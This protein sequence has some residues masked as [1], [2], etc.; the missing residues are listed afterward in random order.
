MSCLL[1]S[2]PGGG[3]GKT[4]WGLSL[5][6]TGCTLATADVVRGAVSHW[7]CADPNLAQTWKKDT[8]LPDEM[9]D[10]VG[11]SVDWVDDLNQR[12]LAVFVNAPHSRAQRLLVDQ[13]G[14][15]GLLTGP[16]ADGFELEDPH[17]LE[18]RVVGASS[19]GQPAPASV[20]DG[21]FFFEQGDL[22]IDAIE[23]SG[24]ALP[25]ASTSRCLAAREDQCGG[26]E[27]YGVENG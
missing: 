19:R 5:M 16:A 12:A 24:Q 9:A 1:S 14:P 2:R 8:Q 23:L 17:A 7:P 22:G 10:E 26:G 3:S 25:G 15:G 4:I 11:E 6:R 21:Q 13:K 27:R 20:L 18:G